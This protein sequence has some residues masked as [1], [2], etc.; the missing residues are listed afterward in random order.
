MKKLIFTILL[1]LLIY[2]VKAVCSIND[3]V[4]LKAYVNN[5]TSTID[6]YIDNDEAYFNVH[7]SNVTPDMYII[8]SN[9][10]KYNY[11]D[12]QDELVIYSIKKNVN[13]TFYSNECPDEKIS[14]LSIKVPIYNK[15]YNSDICIGYTELSW[16]KK[17]T[18]KIYTEDEILIL[19]NKYIKSQEKKISEQEES[20]E[21]NFLEIVNKYYTKY[22]Y[23]VLPIIIVCGIILI[24]IVSKKQKFELFD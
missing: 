20:D 15:Y 7:L 10:T 17:W 13:L 6:Y 5:V 8:D 2:N 11:N 18:K 14:T 3:L 22:Y 9:N 19:K 1:F 23:Y 24:I 16:C 4:R 21:R 12:M